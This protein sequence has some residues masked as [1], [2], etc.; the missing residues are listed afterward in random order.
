M[1]G[2]RVWS[3]VFDYIKSPLLTKLI[4]VEASFFIWSDLRLSWNI[5]TGLR[6]GLR[7]R[8][9][10]I[11]G[12]FL[13]GVNSTTFVFSSV[14]TAVSFDVLEFERTDEVEVVSKPESESSR[15]MFFADPGGPTWPPGSVICSTFMLV[16]MLCL[17]ILKVKSLT[18]TSYRL[19]AEN[20]RFCTVNLGVNTINSNYRKGYFWSTEVS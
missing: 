15:P 8:A 3:S 18:A 9:R 13:R 19:R 14:E 7:F 6:S 12:G 16:K 17:K 20:V 4:K 10:P 11:N 1:D 5:K 2:L